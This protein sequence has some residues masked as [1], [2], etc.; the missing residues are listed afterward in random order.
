[1]RDPRKAWRAH[2]ADSLTG[3]EV[4][5]LRDARTMADLG[6]GAGFPGLVLALALPGA[7]IDLVESVAR[8]CEF[9]RDA[10]AQ[11]GIPNARVVNARSEEHAAPGAPGREA[12]DAVTARAVARLAT[13]AELSS[14]LLRD[15]GVLVAW[16]GRRD[17]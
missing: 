9:M 14:P 7:R 16:K 1:M 6:A 10:V 5:A 2:V 3:L 15:G 13:L 4:P 8:K 11:A 17:P 12:Y